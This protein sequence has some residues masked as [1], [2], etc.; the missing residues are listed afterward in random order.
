[1]QNVVLHIGHEHFC[2]S[3]T[4]F[5]CS[6]CFEANHLAIQSTHHIGRQKQLPQRAASGS[7]APFAS[8]SVQRFCSLMSGVACIQAKHESSSCHRE[9][10]P[11]IRDYYQHNCNTTNLICIICAIGGDQFLKGVDKLFHDA[12]LKVDAAQDGD[13]PMQPIL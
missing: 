10:D 3:Q 2:C 9:R 8:T 11:A 5:A 13:R 1:M 7:G 4:S 6:L 12:A